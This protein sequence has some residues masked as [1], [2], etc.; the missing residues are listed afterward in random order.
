MYYFTN[1]KARNILIPKNT[2]M[3]Q[4][5]KEMEEKRKQSVMPTEECPIDKPYVIKTFCD[6]CP[7]SLPIYNIRTNNC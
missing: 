5:Q 3:E 7:E 2:T 4:I 6:I 1:L